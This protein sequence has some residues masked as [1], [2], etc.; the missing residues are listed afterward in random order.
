MNRID[1]SSNM[2]PMNSAALV[3]EIAVD[4]GY[5]AEEE[6]IFKSSDGP[7]N[8]LMD[9]SNDKDVHADFYNGELILYTIS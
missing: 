6:Q 2:K 1:S 8:L 3:D 5:T 9:L 4:F 7:A